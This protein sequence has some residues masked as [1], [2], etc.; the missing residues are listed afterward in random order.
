MDGTTTYDAYLERVTGGRWRARILDLS[1]CWADGTTEQAALDGLMAAIPAYFAWLRA[2]D[3]YTP[4]VSG[5]F[6]VRPSESQP[7]GGERG[8]LVGAFF[9]P[10]ALPADDDE[11]DWELALLR[12]AYDDLLAALPTARGPQGFGHELGDIVLAQ[13][14]L[15]AAFDPALA[16][17]LGA[18]APHEPAAYLAAFAE[19]VIRGLRAATPEQR[20][21]VR[22]WL[23][24]RWSLRKVLR[25]GIELVREQTLASARPANGAS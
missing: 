13:H 24:G 12:W 3:E 10:D 9:A 16:P 19:T 17:D 5:P 11:L 15:L 18:E 2:H 14:G 25:R 1:G 20:T 8:N 6:A 4:V 21:A 23:G 22:D 7:A